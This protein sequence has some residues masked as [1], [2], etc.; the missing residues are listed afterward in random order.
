GQTR[1][2]EIWPCSSLPVKTVVAIQIDAFVSAYGPLPSISRERSTTL[3]LDTSPLP[4]ASP[5]S[6]NTVAAPMV[7]TYQSDLVATKV[8]L[9]AAWAMRAPGRVQWMQNVNWGG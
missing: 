9:D 7:S 4:L 8:T 3:H 5:G 2:I 6:P 1:D